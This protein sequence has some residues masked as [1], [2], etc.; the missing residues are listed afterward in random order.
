[1]DI[2]HD[3]QSMTSKGLGGAQIRIWCARHRLQLPNS[4]CKPTAPL[5]C[6]SQRTGSPG[7]SCQADEQGGFSFFLR[8]HGM[9]QAT[10]GECTKTCSY[11]AS[12]PLA[13]HLPFI[14]SKDSMKG[15]VHV[16]VY[17][18]LIHMYV[19]FYISVL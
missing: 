18:L 17:P 15:C 7:R 4:K 19:Y 8:H 10:Q 11:V 13:P 1:M 5:I 3:C 16:H 12:S 2:R 6:A 14:G 9:G